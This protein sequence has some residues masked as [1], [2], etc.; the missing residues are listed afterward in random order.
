MNKIVKEFK[1]DLCGQKFVRNFTLRR[2]IDRQHLKIL[3]LH[4]PKYN[5]KTTFNNL[6]EW[7]EHIIF[8][9]TKTSFVTEQS[10]FNGN[11]SEKS[12]LF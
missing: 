8:H 11:F 10:A 3:K 7:R 12:K 6:S 1:C 9:K 5:C 4:C 2:H